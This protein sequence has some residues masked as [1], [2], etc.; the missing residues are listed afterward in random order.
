MTIRN[1]LVALGAALAAFQGCSTGSEP[2]PD[3]VVVLHVRG[4]VTTEPSGEPV[5]GAQV[6]IGSG[7]QASVPAVRKSTTSDDEGR[8]ELRDTLSHDGACPFLW[9]HADADGY[10]P[11]VDFTDPRA[12]VACSEATQVIDLPMRAPS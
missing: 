7:G 6:S 1:A 9:M 12:R 4:K 10:V 8:Y 2:E 3:Q 5:V 11:L